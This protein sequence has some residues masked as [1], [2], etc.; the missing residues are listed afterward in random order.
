MKIHLSTNFKKIS[1]KVI[2]LADESLKHNIVRIK[3]KDLAMKVAVTRLVM[4]SCDD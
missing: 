1:L 2:Q 3:S 4:I